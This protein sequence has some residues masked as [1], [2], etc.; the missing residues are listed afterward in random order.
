MLV[1]VLYV[2]SMIRGLYEVPWYYKAATSH[3]PRLPFARFGFSD[4]IVEFC[5]EFPFLQMVE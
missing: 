2:L 5:D 1:R 3:W 4:T